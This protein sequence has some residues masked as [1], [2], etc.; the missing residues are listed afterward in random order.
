[1]SAFEYEW[2]LTY[3]LDD[4]AAAGPIREGFG[5]DEKG[6]RSAVA[7]YETNPNI[8]ELKLWCRPKP[9]KWAQA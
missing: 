6:A 9:A 4:G 2:R 7:I 3:S 1:M 8:T 5:L